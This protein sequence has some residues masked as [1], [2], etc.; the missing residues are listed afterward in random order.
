MAKGNKQETGRSMLRAAYEAFR[1]GDVVQ[2]RDLSQQVLAG[3][4]GKDDA[5]AAIAIAAEL[6]SENEKIEPTIE[7]VAK[8]LAARTI[9]PPRPYIFVAAAAATLVTLVILAA[10]RY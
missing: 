2:A 4:V 10:V 1:R 7:A 5:S 3:K 9:V 6:S 8:D